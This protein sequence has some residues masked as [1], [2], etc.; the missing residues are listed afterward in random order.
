[1]PY[2]LV[3]DYAKLKGI[4]RQAVED[5]ISR[6]TLAA[7]MREVRVKRRMVF[8]NAEEVQALAR[9]QTEE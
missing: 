9:M 1:M 8:V 6:K 3:A 2:M 4:T 5:R 7:K